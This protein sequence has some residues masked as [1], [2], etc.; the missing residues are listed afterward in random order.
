[1]FNIFKTINIPDINAEQFA[2]K[3]K[4]EENPV[5]LDVRTKR[6]FDSGHIPGSVH[7]NMQEVTFGH[8]L[9]DLD[10]DAT[11]LVYCRS[12]RRSKMACR[13][14]QGKGFKNT[15]NLAGGILQ[16]PENVEVSKN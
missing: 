9:D 2:L 1:M 5:V 7:L 16:W 15:Y 3:M 14:M 11:Y 10:K 4:E 6:E 12:G 13:I 8:K